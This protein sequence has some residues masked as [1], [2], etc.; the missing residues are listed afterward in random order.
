MQNISL[1]YLPISKFQLKFMYFRL[2]KFRQDPIFW[3]LKLT[4]YE[5]LDGL[6]CWV[7]TLMG[8]THAI[9]LFSNADISYSLI[10]VTQ[11]GKRTML[12]ISFRA[13][14]ACPNFKLSPSPLVWIH[15]GYC[16]PDSYLNFCLLHQ[17]LSR[18]ANGYGI[19]QKP[20]SKRIWNF[21]KIL[22]TF[23]VCV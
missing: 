20:R 17:L 15:Y 18:K 6:R 3:S 12:R 5:L 9:H 16:V 23:L 19:F 1:E 11:K 13:G 8:P 4:I 14:F 10:L 21:P 22:A 7:K 2:L